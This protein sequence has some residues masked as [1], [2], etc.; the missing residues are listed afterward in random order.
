MDEYD[1]GP[2]LVI[3]L[4]CGSHDMR[5]IGFYRLTIVNGTFGFWGVTFL[6]KK[7]Q[8]CYNVPCFSE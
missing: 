5:H 8:T 2:Y 6:G 4:M 7:N 1:D 3:L